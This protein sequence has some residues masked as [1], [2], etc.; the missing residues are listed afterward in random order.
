MDFDSPA[1]DADLLRQQLMSKHPMDRIKALCALEVEPAPGASAEQVAAAGAAA[2]FAARGIP[3]YAAHDAQYL[4]W[5]DKAVALWQRLHA[6]PGLVP[7]AVRTPAV[8]VVR[9]A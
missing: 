7:A 3:F 1:A 6:A 4:A 5:V 2:R 8:S 9:H